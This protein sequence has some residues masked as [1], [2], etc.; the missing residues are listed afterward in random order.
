[1]YMYTI[2]GSPQAVQSL[3]TRERGEKGDTVDID[4]Y[5]YRYQYRYINRCVDN[6]DHR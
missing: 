6:I 3:L 2:T 4:I 5:R 1:M